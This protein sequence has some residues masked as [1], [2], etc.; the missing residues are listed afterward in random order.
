MTNQTEYEKWRTGFMLKCPQEI[1]FFLKCRH[2]LTGIQSDYFY[3]LTLNLFV[4]EIQFIIMRCRGYEEVSLTRMD[5][6]Q[7]T[8]VVALPGCYQHC[9]RWS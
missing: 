1:N 6:C 7:G 2:F 9:Y 5:P 3:V 8:R 4:S